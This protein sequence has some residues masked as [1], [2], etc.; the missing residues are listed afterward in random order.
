ME[1]YLHQISDSLKEIEFKLSYDEIKDELNKEVKKLTQKIQIDGFRKGKVPQ[2]IIKKMF[3][4]A[5]EIEASEKVANNYFWN[6]VDSEN[7]RVIDKPV[8]KDINL[9]IGE[10]L[11]FKIQFE[12]LP[13]IEVKDYTDIEI[14]IPDYQITDKE[15]EQE[16]NE[17]LF[18]NREFIDAEEV[19]DNN[20]LLDVE[21]TRTDENGNPIEN[22]KTEKLSIDLSKDS[23]HPEILEKAKNKKVGDTFSFH[24]IEETNKEEN[25]EEQNSK[26]EEYYYLIKI[27]GI[28]KIITPELNDEFVS[29]ITKEKIKTVDEFKK[30]LTEKLKN[31][32][33]SR[34]EELTKIKL[35]SEIVKRNDFTPPKSFVDKLLQDYVDEEE[36]YFKRNRISFDRNEAAQRLSKRAEN[37]IKWLLIQDEIIKKENITVTDEEIDNEIKLESEKSGLPIDNIKQYYSSSKRKEKILE[38]KLFDLLFEK[39][40]IKKVSPE[41]YFKREEKNEKQD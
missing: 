17:I 5:F 19:I 40:K 26:K 15:I 27:N 32:Y 22:T 16:I 35:I 28:K 41:T 13:L 23:V 9:K 33:E 30:D 34:N 25:Q 2:H 29:K 36:Q 24:F 4:D 21:V 39:N 31:Y 37:D 8:L 11:K 18:A 12:T 14:E 7:I 20:Y 6:F 10:E 3:G 38:K 1:Y